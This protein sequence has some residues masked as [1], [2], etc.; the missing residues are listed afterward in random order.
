MIFFHAI[1]IAANI[2][3]R[4]WQLIDDDERRERKTNG[5]IKHENGQEI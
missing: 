1:F 3:A 5:D 4:P 2:L